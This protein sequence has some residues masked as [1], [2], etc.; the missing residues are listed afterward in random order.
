MG[1]Y[2]LSK[3]FITVNKLNRQ[4]VMAKERLSKLQYYILSKL[5]EAENNCIG[6]NEIY[7]FFGSET[8]SERVVVSRSLKRL[9]EKGLID[10]K[11]RYKNSKIRL[12]EEKERL[13]AYGL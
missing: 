7:E 3:N 8:K 4:E 2:G 9:R 11:M 13:K 5:C 12:K 1:G 6:R 10:C